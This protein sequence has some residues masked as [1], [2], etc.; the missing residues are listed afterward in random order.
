MCPITVNCYINGQKRRF[1][2]FAHERMIDIIRDRF[3][4]TGTKEGCGDGDCGACTV[5]WGVPENGKVRYR[6]V[7]ACLMSAVNMQGA[8]IITVEGLAENGVLSLVQEMIIDKHGIQC[9]FCSPGIIMSMTGYLAHAQKPTQEGLVHSLTGNICRCTGYEGIIKA[10]DAV[11]AYMTEHPELDMIP[12]QVRAVEPEVLKMRSR[13]HSSEYILPGTLAEYDHAVAQHPDA[14]IVSGNTD[15]GVRA[16]ATLVYPNTMVDVSRI[17]ETKGVALVAEGLSIGG[18]LSLSDIQENP[19]VAEYLPV[20]NDALTRMASPQIRNVATLAGNICNASPIGDMVVLLSLL[21]A[22]ALVHAPEYHRDIPLDE[23]FTGYK[24]TVL[25]PLELIEAF[26]IPKEVLKK[27]RI[28][29]LKSSKR[30]DVDIASVN[31]ASRLV[32]ENG[33]VTSWRIAFGGVASNVIVLDMPPV[34]SDASMPELQALGRSVAER[35]IPLSDV[36]GSAEYRKALVAG[37]VVRH[38]LKATGREE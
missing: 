30:K 29:F 32:C 17:Q 36:R 33:A 10:C 6:S 11:I 35:F 37:H 7:A 18:G 28:T 20:M 15:L 16:H 31:S 25:R 4:L 5:V 19:L 27:G 21:D 24:Q 22:H 14:V 13:R 26:I 1:T 9:G 23:F 3:F 12:G 34:A 2:A 38:Y 8:S